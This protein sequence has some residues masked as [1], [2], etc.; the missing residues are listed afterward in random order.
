MKINRLNVAVR[1]LIAVF[2]VVLPV[3]GCFVSYPFQSPVEA[4]SGSKTSPVVT[5]KL[6]SKLSID[7]QQQLA[8]AAKSTQLAGSLVSVI[9]QT[10]AAPSSSLVSSLRVLGGLVTK[11]YTNVDA[12]SVKIPFRSLNNLAAKTEVRYIS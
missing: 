7:L 2:L 1:M 6:L 11:G 10:E 4:Q 9:V 12:F 5:R 8:E 3:V